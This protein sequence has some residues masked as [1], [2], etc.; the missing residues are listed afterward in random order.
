[1][2]KAILNYKGQ[3]TTILSKKGEKMKDILKKF[4]KKIQKDSNKLYIIYDGKIVNEEL[5]FDEILNSDDKERNVMNALV[6]EIEEFN[7][8]NNG[9]IIKSKNI[10]CP[11]CKENILIK[12]DDYNVNLFHCKNGHELNNLSIKDF[13]S[14][15]YINISNIICSSCKEKNKGNTYNN[16][17]YFCLTCKENLC[18]LCQKQH[19]QNHIITQYENK[20]NICEIHKEP[21]TKYCKQCNKNICMKCESEHKKHNSVYFG[22]LLPDDE[23][24]KEISEFKNEIDKFNNDIKNMIQMLE[25]VMKNINYFYNI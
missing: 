7:E 15:Q 2:S 12:F 8:P 4:C 3:E 9:N 18:P 5:T 21:F 10:I 6:D 25:N 22:D 19:E 24:I 17:F 23:K 13:E 14:T 20:D 1:M 16:E 11:K